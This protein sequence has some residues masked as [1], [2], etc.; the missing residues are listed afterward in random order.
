MSQVRREKKGSMA[1]FR[2]LG[3]EA[4]AFCVASACVGDTLEPPEPEKPADYK[5][6]T[7]YG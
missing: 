1:S 4:K 3:G 2:E 6:P 5:D 7:C